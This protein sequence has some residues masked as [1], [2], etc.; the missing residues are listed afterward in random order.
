MNKTNNNNL[1]KT[2][3]KYCKDEENNKIREVFFKIIIKSNKN[4]QVIEN[5]VENY[6]EYLER[7]ELFDFNSF[8]NNLD[9]VIETYSINFLID[10]NGNFYIKFDIYYPSIGSILKYKNSHCIYHECENIILNYSDYF[11]P[12]HL[13]DEIMNNFEVVNSCFYQKNKEL[14]ELYNNYNEQ[15]DLLNCLK[16]KPNYNLFKIT[17]NKLE[18]NDLNECIEYFF[19]LI[20]ETS[21]LIEI[22]LNN[23]I[24]DLTFEDELNSHN[25]NSNS[26]IDTDTENDLQNLDNTCNFEDVIIENNN[27]HNNNYLNIIEQP[28]KLED[29]LEDKLYKFDEKEKL[30]SFLKIKELLKNIKNQETETSC[31][32]IETSDMEM[33]DEEINNKETSD[34][35]MSDEE[36]NNKETSDEEMSDEEM[37]DEEMSDEEMSGEELTENNL[38]KILNTL[39]SINFKN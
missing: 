16:N 35:E 31:E 34:E 13:T 11:C 14:E 15:S 3:K 26:D 1:L 24:D 28:I 25:S 5:D 30:E 7:L 18:D 32:E 17:N 19:E 38:S 10:N 8:F 39:K 33:S 12:I 6:Q 9:I 21:K 36:I 20:E 29:K 4:N 22:D 37:S 27:E 23:D 2:Y